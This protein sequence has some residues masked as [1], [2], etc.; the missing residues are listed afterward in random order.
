MRIPA[1][2]FNCIFCGVG[3]CGSDGCG[4]N[5]CGVDECVGNCFVFAALIWRSRLIIC[6]ASTCSYVGCRALYTRIRARSSPS[7]FLKAWI[8]SIRLI[9]KVIIV[10]ARRFSAAADWALHCGMSVRRCARR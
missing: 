8:A 2:S 3:G 7:L 6:F 9:S 10:S 4:A 1:I 5:R